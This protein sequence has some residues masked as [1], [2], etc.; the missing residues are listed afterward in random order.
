MPGR[1]QRP[2]AGAEAEAVVGGGGV[3]RGSRLATRERRETLPASSLVES[4][5]V[6][7]EGIAA[8]ILGL[9]GCQMAQQ[10]GPGETGTG[11]IGPGKSPG[12]RRECGLPKLAS[13][14]G[15]QGEGAG[16][17]S[18]VAGMRSHLLAPRHVK[19]VAVSFLPTS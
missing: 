1:R 15:L 2:D 17:T 3:A 4:F 7:N 18:I 14:R 8:A 9:V 6:E 10:F 13:D 16:K 5:R 11:Q 19:L 12:S